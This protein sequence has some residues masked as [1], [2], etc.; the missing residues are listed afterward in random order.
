MGGSV[1][2]PL[3]DL[4][5]T[6]MKVMTI[7][8]TS[9]QMSHAHIATFSTLNPVADYHQPMPP[10][11]TLGHSQAS[12]AHSLGGTLL[13]SHGSG[14]VQGFISALQE[15]V[16][17]V[18]CKFHNQIPLAFKVK[19]PGDSQSL[20]QIPRLGKLLWVLIFS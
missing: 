3:C 10:P 16:S 13:L 8:V 5:P 2:S 9:F 14:C 6:M 20:C 12:L 1:F 18:L 11:E 17:P 7:M 15:S 4:R 19:F